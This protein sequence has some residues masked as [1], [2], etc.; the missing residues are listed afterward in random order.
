MLRQDWNLWRVCKRSLFLCF[1][2][3]DVSLEG[4][5]PFIRLSDVDAG[6][7]FIP[8]TARTAHPHIVQIA[9]RFLELWHHK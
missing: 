9:I 6:L 7:L 2:Y 5:H 8:G 3:R 4:S 1:L